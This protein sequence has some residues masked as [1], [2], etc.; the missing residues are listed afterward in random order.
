MKKLLKNFVNSINGLKVSLKENSFI[1]EVVG[2]FILI[3]YLVLV[4][5][6]VIYKFIIIT[7]YFLLLAF[8][9]INTAVEKLSDKITKD[10]DSDIKK[11]KDISSA[12]VFVIFLLLISL[13]FLTHYV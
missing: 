9:L 12:A 1:L 3:P 6:D 4:E 8:E 5:L 11:I 2:G 7:V 13:L 10:L